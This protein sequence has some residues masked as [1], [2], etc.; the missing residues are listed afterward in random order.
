MAEARMLFE[1]ALASWESTV[2]P[3]HPQVAG[4][5]TY[6]AELDLAAKKYGDAES[7]L[8]RALTI[9]EKQLGADHPYTGEMM[10][11]HAT[12]LRKTG[13]KTEAKRVE[14][15]ARALLAKHA[16]DNLTNHTVDFRT[17]L[18]ATPGAANDRPPAP[19]Q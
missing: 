19:L 18:T 8:V 5:L 14:K 16:S 2:G 13:R 10:N 9:A 17:L 4:A 1:R 12:V 7:R 11:L 3:N 15:R 6:L